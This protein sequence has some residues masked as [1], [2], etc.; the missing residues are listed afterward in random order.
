MITPQGSEP[1][2]LQASA[3]RPY[4]GRPCYPPVGEVHRGWAA[5]VAALPRR[6]RTLA[7]DG[8]SAAYWDQIAATV[9]AEL[10]AHGFAARIQLVDMRAAGLPWP[11]IEARTRS[12]A[13]GDDPD[14]EKLAAGSLADLI[15]GERIAAGPVPDAT[16]RLVFGPGAALVA[17]DVLWWADLPKRYAER[18]SARA[19]GTCWHRP[20]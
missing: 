1:L 16:V 9:S 11:E 10:T 2:P 5:A 6:M 13:L 4:V 8:P 19:A 15:D 3:E 17:P 14:F 12:A 18:P 7:V 20:R